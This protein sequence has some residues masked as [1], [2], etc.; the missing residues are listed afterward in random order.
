MVASAQH[1]KWLLQFCHGASACTRSRVE[2]E[3]V[4]VAKHG[5]T[6]RTKLCTGVV[7]IGC[8]QRARLHRLDSGSGVPRSWV[9]SGYT[10]QWDFPGDT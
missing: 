1:R 9:E 4:G 3:L 10:W 6:W 8:P 5:A 7:R 2:T